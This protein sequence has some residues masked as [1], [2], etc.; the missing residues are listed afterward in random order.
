MFSQLVYQ[1]FSPYDQTALWSAQKLVAAE[2]NDIHPRFQRFAYNRFAFDADASKI[3]YRSGT[4]VFIKQQ[5]IRVR[6][7]SDL[8]HRRHCRESDYAIVGRM[9]LEDQF[10][11]LI[12]RVFVIG[13]PGAVG[14]TDLS[15]HGS[16]LSQHIRDTKITANLDEFSARYRN[17]GSGSENGQHEK[18]RGGAVVHDK[19]GLSAR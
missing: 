11:I 14:R 18:C 19:C 2:G 15:E 3:E 12:D 1:L 9:Y 10:C 16:R 13:D 6:K 7:I 4:G 8:F 17:V 5:A